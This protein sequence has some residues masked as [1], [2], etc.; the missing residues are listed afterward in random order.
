MDKSVFACSKILLAGLFLWAWDAFSLQIIRV[1]C[2]LWHGGKRYSRHTEQIKEDKSGAKDTWYLILWE[3]DDEQ[4]N[5]RVKTVL[6]NNC[7]QGKM[8]AVELCCR[9]AVLLIASCMCLCSR[10]V[11][12]SIVLRGWW[13]IFAARREISTSWWDKRCTFVLRSAAFIWCAQPRPFVLMLCLFSCSR[14]LACSLS[15]SWSTQSRTWTSES[16]CSLSSPNWAW[17]I[18]SR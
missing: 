6:G 12:R 11:R 17:M 9:R 7:V 8:I 3:N 2:D 14:L 5:R 16:I 10:C 15:T 18:T 4:S 13:I 1:R